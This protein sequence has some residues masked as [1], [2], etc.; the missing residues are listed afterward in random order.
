MPLDH[1]EPLQ[2]QRY[3]P[4]GF[5]TL[6]HD[7]FPGLQRGGLNSSSEPIHREAQESTQRILTTLVY[8]NTLSPG[9]GGHTVFPGVTVAE[10]PWLDRSRQGGLEFCR[11]GA[12]LAAAAHPKCGTG[13]VFFPTVPGGAWRDEEALHGSCPVAEG[14]TKWVAQVSWRLPRHHHHTLLLRFD[15]PW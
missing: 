6:H 8:L 7:A 9:A 12:E 13:L 4:G 15:A 11:A 14:H 10:A 3:D 2:I 1:G 5:Y